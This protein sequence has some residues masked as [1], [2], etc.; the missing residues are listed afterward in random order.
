MCY[1]AHVRP[2][3]PYEIGGSPQRLWWFALMAAAASDAADYRTGEPAVM[4]IVI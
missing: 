1:R 3:R 4:I 2:G